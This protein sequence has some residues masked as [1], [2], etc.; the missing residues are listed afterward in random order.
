MRGALAATRQALDLARTHKE[1]GHRAWAL[2]LQGEIASRGARPDVAKAEAAYLEAVALAERLGMRPLLALSRLGLARLHRRVGD[3]AKA[4]EHLS[5]AIAWLHQMDMPFWLEQ[6]EGEIRELG[7]PFVV[8]GPNAELYR[9][10]KR[11]FSGEA[12]V[13]ILHDRRRGERRQRRAPHQP[14]GRR[15]ERR[16]QAASAPS[17]L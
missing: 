4:E 12:T 3:R 7:G 9:Y 1:E 13:T 6:A 5:A 15:G 2:R 17:S 10:L 8:P 16:R 11:R 14:E